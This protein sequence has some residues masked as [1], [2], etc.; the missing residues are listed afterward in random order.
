MRAY[1]AEKK[2]KEELEAANADLS[3][4]VAEK[5]KEVDEAKAK[6]A[7]LKRLAKAE[8]EKAIYAARKATSFKYQEV[9]PKY[10]AR[11]E[12]VDEATVILKKLEQCQDNQEFIEDILNNQVTN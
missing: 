3:S 2:R 12:K 10:W 1:Y 9:S 4:L 11:K 8:K 6:V 5:Q 7:Q